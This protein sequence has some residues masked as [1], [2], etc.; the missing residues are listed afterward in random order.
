MRQNGGRREEKESAI[1]S[2]VSKTSYSELIVEMGPDYGRARDHLDGS[3]SRLF[4]C[5]PQSSPAGAEH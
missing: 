1:V 4:A 5:V 3:S 2:A